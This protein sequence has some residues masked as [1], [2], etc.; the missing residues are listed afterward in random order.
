M[1]TGELLDDVTAFVGRY[2]VLPDEAERIAIALFTLHTWA[3][4]AAHATPYL[5]VVSPERRTGKT[6]LLDVLRVLVREPWYATSPTEAVLFRKISRDR[7]TL[8]LD[9]IDAIFGSAGERTE[10]VRA[11]LNAGNRAGASVPRCVGKGS[12]LVD[13]EVFCAKV[14]AGIRT[15]RLPDTIVDRAIV[16]RMKR[17][18]AG[19]PV[20]RFRV[21]RAS[22]QASDLGL[23]LEDWS[24]RHTAAL[25]DA[26]PDLP[27]ELND[28]AMD[29]WEPLVAIA[30]LA[31]G[32]W[33]ARARAAAIA[34]SGNGDEDDATYGAQ[35]LTAIKATMNGRDKIPTAELLRG[36]QRGRRAAVR[37]LERRQGDQRTGS[38]AVPQAVRRP[39]AQA[40]CRGGD[41][42]R[43]PRR[44]PER[45]LP[46]V[47]PAGAGT[48]GTRGTRTPHRAAPTPMNTGMFRMFRMFRPAQDMTPMGTSGTSCSSP[49]TDCRSTLRWRTTS[50]NEVPGRQDRCA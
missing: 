13:F 47:C 24:G 26:E 23:W 50:A 16:I 21:R 15:N 40:A 29:A 49:P 2:V 43:L 10:P 41:H 11:I 18:H 7:P 38:R 1:N 20:D 37:R 22:E 31:G 17:R 12:E 42:P 8:L 46:A 32:E 45:R 9:E 6:R 35:L 36:D 30:D 25:A 19:E 34:L 28:R 48:S 5:V 44:R 33:P 4:G 27:D 14:L 3:F 39:P